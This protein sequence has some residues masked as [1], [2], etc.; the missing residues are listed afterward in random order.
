M[1]TFNRCQLLPL[2]QLAEPA[3]WSG[4]D[5]G[6]SYQT[7]SSRVLQYP[8]RAAVQCTAEQRE[9]AEVLVDGGG[10]QTGGDRALAR[11]E[12]QPGRG[13]L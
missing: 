11:T 2:C 12:L 4:A 6:S 13:Q 8:L 1:C 5:T 9:R 7:Q 10:L 3:G